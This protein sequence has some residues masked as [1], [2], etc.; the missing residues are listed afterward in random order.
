MV[1]EEQRPQRGRTR[2]AEERAAYAKRLRR[3]RLADTFDEG[4]QLIDEGA[5]AGC[6]RARGPVW[7]AGGAMALFYQFSRRTFADFV[8]A[9]REWEEETAL[10]SRRRR[11][12][13]E[14]EV[15]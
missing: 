12:P 4:E 13:L 9:G 7:R 10:P 11:V 14:D 6:A 8:K 2:L 3:R 5:A 1:A 15:D